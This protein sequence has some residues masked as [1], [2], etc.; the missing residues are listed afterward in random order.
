MH[1]VRKRYRVRRSGPLRGSVRV[2][3]DKSI[4]HRSL[5]FGALGRGVSRVAG[6]SEGLDN[7][8]TRRACRARGGASE[9]DDEGTVIWTQNDISVTDIS[10]FGETLI[11]DTSAAN[12]RTTLGFGGASTTGT[13][14]ASGDVRLMFSE[15]SPG[16]LLLA[17]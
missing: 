7:Q 16:L 2:P 12:A 1:S 14:T 8:A 6:L 17:E 5:I 10:T 15:T 3:G 4:G 13:G 11:D 9:S